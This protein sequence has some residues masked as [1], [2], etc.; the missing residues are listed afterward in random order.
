MVPNI[1]AHTE[2]LQIT[3]LQETCLCLPTKCHQTSEG[4][5]IY[6]LDGALQLHIRSRLEIQSSR[7]ETGRE[8]SSFENVLFTI[9]R[10]ATYLN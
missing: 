6:T 10:I 3:N 1:L 9:T 2:F 4:T 5:H 7:L 8:D